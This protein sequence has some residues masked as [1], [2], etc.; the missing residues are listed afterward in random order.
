MSRLKEAFGDART[1]LLT[2]HL[3]LND[4]KTKS[5]YIISPSSVAKYG[6]MAIQLDKMC[7]LAADTV[8]LLS[9]VYT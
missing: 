9:A 8:E 5:L 1:R 6:R 2:H 4:G 3:Q 7:V